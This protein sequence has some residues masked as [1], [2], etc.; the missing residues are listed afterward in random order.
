MS[1]T[2]QLDQTVK[3]ASRYIYNAPLLYTNDGEVAFKMGDDV[4]QFILSP[5]FG[6]R[7][8]RAFLPPIQTIVGQ[9]DYKVAVEDFGWLE[10][11][12]VSLP[13]YSF[14]TD[15]ILTATRNNNTVTLILQSNPANLGFQ[16]GQTVTVADVTD[17]SFNGSQ[18]FVLSSLSGNTVQYFQSGANTTSTGGSLMYPV[19]NGTGL[20]KTQELEVKNPLAE[21]TELGLPAFIG[22]V[23]D[24]N[25]GNITFR[26]QPVPDQVYTLNI[27]YQKAAKTFGSLKDTW[28]PIPDYLSYLYTNGF[29]AAS[30]EYKGDERFAFAR[31]EFLRQT[32]AAADSISDEAKNIFLEPRLS[33]I[34]QTQSTQQMGT[35]ARQ[36]RIS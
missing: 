17:T 34:R 23:G 26:I 6:W 22:A 27:I 9:T 18:S 29:V 1:S 32:L 36:G 14:I 13:P 2:L 10:K 19:S 30:Y 21:V 35:L 12:S 5:P 8:N 20:L 7:W 31:Q 28:W 15:P 3:I 25:N 24:D 11:A 4:R 33:D 16:G